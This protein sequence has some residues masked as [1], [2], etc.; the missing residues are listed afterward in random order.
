MIKENAVITTITEI[1]DY[2]TMLIYR[3]GIFPPIKKMNAFCRHWIIPSF[4]PD[5]GW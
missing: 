5:I 3:K 4:T 1:K 2:N